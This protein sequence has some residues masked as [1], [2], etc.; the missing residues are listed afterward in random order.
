MPTVG[1]DIGCNSSRRIVGF[2]N[3]PSLMPTHA[4]QLLS[5][6]V[7]A[8]VALLAHDGELKPD[9]DDEIV[10]GSCVTREAVV[11]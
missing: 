10:A 11:A 8:L 6:N 4:S 3:V 2:T 5:R 1:S 9:W 7:A